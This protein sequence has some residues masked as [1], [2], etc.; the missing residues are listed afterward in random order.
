MLK[1]ILSL[2]ILVSMLS[3]DA[4]L[5]LSLSSK[6]NVYWV[7]GLVYWA[8]FHCPRIQLNNAL[9]HLAVSSIPQKLIHQ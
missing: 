4:S 7:T 2:S 8:A 1:V 6:T 3:V 9:S 5:A